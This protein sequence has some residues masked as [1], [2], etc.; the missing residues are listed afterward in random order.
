MFKFKLGLA[1]VFS[2]FCF[3][4]N[5]ADVSSSKTQEN[6]NAADYLSHEQELIKNNI[7]LMNK[8]GINIIPSPKKM[9]IK[10]EKIYIN[11]SNA[12]MIAGSEKKH[13]IGAEFINKFFLDNNTAAIPVKNEKELTPNEDSKIKI[14]IGEENS[15]SLIKNAL[16]FKFPE[17]AKKT[18]SYIIKSNGEKKNII[19]A[20]YDSIGT[21]YAAV[22]FSKLIKKDKD[23]IYIN[24]A[25]IVDWPDF[26][27]RGSGNLSYPL[28]SQFLWKTQKNNDLAKQYIDFIIEHKINFTMA[29]TGWPDTDIREYSPELKKGLK[30]INEYAADRG[31]RIFLPQYWNVGT[32]KRD[33]NDPR[34]KDCVEHTGM[35]FCWGNEELLKDKCS[36][37]SEFLKETGFGAVFFHC[38][39]TNTERWDDRCMNCRMKF[40]DNR[41]EADNNVVRHLY[42][43]CKN[44]SPD[45]V[46]AFVFRP[47]SHDWQVKEG[48]KEFIESLTKILPPDINIARRE[49]SKADIV[50]WKKTVK[51]PIYINPY[52][53]FGFDTASEKLFLPSYQYMKG[54]YLNNQQDDILHFETGWPENDIAIVCASEYMWNSNS[55]GAEEQPPIEKDLTFNKTFARKNLMPLPETNK[56][57]LNL[58]ERACGDVYGQGAGKYFYTGICNEAD[59]D[60]INNTKNFVK[61]L[62]KHKVLLSQ[63]S[64]LALMEN[65]YA[66]TTAAYDAL[67]ELFHKIKNGEN[68]E[69][70]K[71]RYPELVYFMINLAGLKANSKVMISQL[72]I[73]EFAK[74]KNQDKIKEEA[75]KGVQAV[76]DGKKEL[77]DISQKL[78]SEPCLRGTPAAFI[79]ESMK[80][81]DDKKASFL[82]YTFTTAKISVPVLST[83]SKNDTENALGT[84][85]IAIFNADLA[86]GKSYGQA[87]IFN[88]L[89]NISGIKA[90]YIKE[91]SLP[92]LMNYDCLIIPDTKKMGDSDLSSVMKSL[93][94]YVTE[95]GKGILFY[96]DSAG[97]YRSPFSINI[98]PEISLG[99]KERKGSES[100]RDEKYK[101]TDR[102]LIIE[103]TNK[104][105]DGFIKGDRQVHSYF[106]HISLT[107]GPQG[108]VCLKDA[109]NDPV[110]VAGKAGTGRVVF[111][112]TIPG[113]DVKDKETEIEGFDKAILLNSIFYLV[114]KEPILI[115]LSQKTRKNEM[116][117][118]GGVAFLRFNIDLKTA[119]PLSGATIKAS[120]YNGKNMRLLKEQNILERKDIKD[121]WQ[122]GDAEIKVVDCPYLVVLF[123][124]KSQQGVFF[125][126]F[127]F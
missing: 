127:T 104:I 9:D 21:L 92:V 37:L 122:G 53:R 7:D 79:K 25:D 69:Y 88:V 75:E 74:E 83:I 5:A 80:K 24:K 11:A 106:D 115:T 109:I 121:A 90:E 120:V 71:N 118:E 35:Y 41:A 73:E 17:D 31:I 16:N 125:K 46:T 85:K 57:I 40:G 70:K 14:I 89:K 38:L 43:A 102:E 50:E 51:Q 105:T 98:F 101:D 119:M 62:E 39:E 59:P 49:T 99:A 44:Y 52:H 91:L 60:F 94:D 113:Y 87:P 10:P 61:K 86:N 22:T 103:E 28:R 124:I 30:E 23:G 81:L 84:L 26:K 20:G 111:N 27:Y 96:H 114:Q 2:A 19:L 72:R 47:Y 3:W 15:N 93:R 65:Q 54:Y 29:F 12:V 67:T 110:V 123:E 13:I 68:V 63:D 18:Q 116:L 56:N 77:L 33:K 58:A 126:R 66:K 6:K 107:S 55:P 45:V 8:Y 32:V 97:Y 117:D 82:Q 36:R 95:K 48:G 100:G 112:G 76:E 42:Q 1:V 108:I 34:F 64:L 4:G 78:S